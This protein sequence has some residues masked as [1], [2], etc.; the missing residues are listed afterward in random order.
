MELSRKLVKGLFALLYKYKMHKEREESGRTG[1]DRM[2]FRSHQKKDN[3]FHPNLYCSCW[4]W[5]SHRHE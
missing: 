2:D 4:R 3:K 1:Q 5:C